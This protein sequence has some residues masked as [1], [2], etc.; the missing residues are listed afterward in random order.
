M[1]LSN[2]LFDIIRFL[3][4]IFFPAVG[5]L[6]LGVSRIW[7]LPFGDEVAKTCVC[8]S[9]FLGCFIGVSRANYNKTAELYD[10][11]EEEK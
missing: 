7:N 2:K 1:K 3:C 10:G 6:Y 4:E 8:I 5:T 9:A 11:I